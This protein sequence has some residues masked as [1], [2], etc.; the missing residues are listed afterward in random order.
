MS[1]FNPVIFIGLEKINVNHQM[2][3]SKA[4]KMEFYHKFTSSQENQPQLINEYKKILDK[5]EGIKSRSK[6]IGKEV[7]RNWVG[8]YL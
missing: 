6:A 5:I 1:A 3:L 2:N 4:S 8:L 7:L